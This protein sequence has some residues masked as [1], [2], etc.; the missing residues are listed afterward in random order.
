MSPPWA[1]GRSTSPNRSP[2]RSP[3]RS[4]A[5]S[6]DRFTATENSPKQLYGLAPT[7][8]AGTH[9]SIDSVGLIS[10]KVSGLETRAPTTAPIG[11]VRKVIKS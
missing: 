1:R 4:P 2:S 10:E 8:V 11:S 7:P 9:A 5:R 3:A 6:L